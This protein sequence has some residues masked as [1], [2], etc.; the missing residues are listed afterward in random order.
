MAA[1]FQAE[2]DPRVIESF[3]CTVAEPEKGR[4]M[5]CSAAKCALELLTGCIAPAP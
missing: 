3:T 4:F 1:S 5:P 2:D